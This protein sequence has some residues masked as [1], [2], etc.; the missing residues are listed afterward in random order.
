MIDHFKTGTALFTTT[1]DADCDGVTAAREYIM[2]YEYQK[3][4][5]KLVRRDGVIQVIARRDIA[6]AKTPQT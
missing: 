1:D 4:D 2:M 5:V 6:W 3:D